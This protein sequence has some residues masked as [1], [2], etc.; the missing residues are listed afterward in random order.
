[1]DGNRNVYAA[2]IDGSGTEGESLDRYAISPWA[3]LGRW[4]KTGKLK[5]ETDRIYRQIELLPE[6]P[7]RIYLPAGMVFSLMNQKNQPAAII[8]RN[9]N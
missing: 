8:H 5:V 9:N 1:M 3:M 6:K 2:K 7:L 4:D